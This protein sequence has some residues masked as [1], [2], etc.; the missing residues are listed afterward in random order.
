MIASAHE[1]I[2]IAGVIM[3][4]EGKIAHLAGIEVVDVRRVLGERDTHGGLDAF[5][6]FVST[7]VGRN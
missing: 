3:N 7:I 5:N 1:E 2:V 6:F 4:T